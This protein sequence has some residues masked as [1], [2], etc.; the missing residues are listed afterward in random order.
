MTADE[1]NQLVEEIQQVLA[2]VEDPAEDELI[3]LAS[4][5]EELVEVAVQRLR[6]VEKLLNKGLRAEAIELAEQSPNLNDIVTALDFP[7]AEIWNDCLVQFSIQP[8]RELPVD[9]AAELNDAY[10]VSAPL[11]RLLQRYRTQSLG[12][13]PLPLR[14]DTL[15][16]LVVEDIANTQWS[17]DLE[18]FEAHRIGELK[19]ELQA[20]VKNKNLAIVATLDTEL[21]S[22][23]W[24]VKVPVAL[25]KNAREAHTRLRQAGARAELEPLCHRLS[26]AY[27]DFDKSAA[28]ALQKRF[29]ALTEILDLAP[30]DPLYDIAGPALD[31]LNEEEARAASEAE[32]EANREQLET[33]LDRNTTI[34]ELERLYSHAVRNGQTLP[35]PLE[36]RLAD[37]IESLRATAAR[38]RIA[39]MSSIV[40]GCLVATVAVVLIIR[41]VTFQRAVDGHVEQA[42]KLLNE[43]QASGDLQPIDDYFATIEADDARFLQQPEILGLKEQLDGIRKQEV[44]RQE[45]LDQLIAD[46]RQLIPEARWNNIGTAD[47]LLHEATAIARNESEKARILNVK[48]Q[49]QNTRLAMQK[50][51]DEVFERDQTAVVDLIAALPTDSLNGYPAVNSRLDE[52]ANRDHVSSELKTALAALKSKLDQQMSM[53]SANL[54]TARSLQNITSSAGTPTKYRKAMLEYTKSHPGTERSEDF[55]AVAKS[56]LSL[57]EGVAEWNSIRSRI[58][59]AS[60]ATTSAADAATIVADIETFIQQSGPYP[61]QMNTDERIAALTAIAAR[62]GSSAG[63][64]AEQVDRMFAPR[65]ISQA[66]LVRSL[67]DGRFYAL[68]LPKVEGSGLRFQHFT[69]TTGTQLESKVLG[70]AKV[71]DAKKKTPDEWR[72]PQTTMAQ[73]LQPLLKNRLNSSFES[74]I[75]FGVDE[76][77][78]AKDVDEILR[79]LLIEKLMKIGAEGSAFTSKKATPHLNRIAAA[80]V[81]RLTNWVSP[82]DKRADA[83]RDLADAFMKKFGQ[84]IVTD[85]KSAV[86]EVKLAN[87]EPVGPRMECVGWLHRNADARWV[88]ALRDELKIS[89][90][91]QLL[92]IGRTA[93]AANAR[94]YP[95]AKVNES[96]IGSIPAL[97]VEGAKEGHPVYREI[98]TK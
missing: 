87:E 12:R 16:Q 14:I 86:D 17:V 37:R 93:T 75:A 46:A 24:T 64:S 72:A 92:A 32:F 41:G 42:E 11:E 43:S 60:L 54:Q 10:S 28:Q 62:A 48:G 51:V 83:E 89:V 71:P 84:Q 57:W 73:R 1:V 44:G 80:G 25:K 20:A 47:T 58:R 34:D 8:V 38:K 26:D 94:F 78:K 68:G 23:Q 27:A 97:E 3:D 76:L 13:D 21:S 65:T 50:K 96:A 31:W 40:A 39:L 9:I 49:L 67:R 2:F 5:H 35:E 77:L 6:E 69:T 56:D 15:R 45:Q 66:S 98:P 53:V 79:L 85:L 30:T 74:G 29:F 22:P 82:D 90:P 91:T 4:R 88:V 95:V 18:K 61:G 63:R 55:L 33:A 59:F 70:L 36:N 52:L 19:K 7:E 81:S